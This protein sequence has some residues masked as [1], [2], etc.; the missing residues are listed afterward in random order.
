ALTS[1]TAT[2]SGVLMNGY[3]TVGALRR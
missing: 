2:S 3:K 1:T